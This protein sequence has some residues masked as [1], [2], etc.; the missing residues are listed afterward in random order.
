MEGT[1]SGDMVGLPLAIH[2]I[3]ELRRSDS[4]LM[5]ATFL[6]LIIYLFVYFDVDHIFLKTEIIIV[7][8]QLDGKLQ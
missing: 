7:Y 2:P 5:L 4:F 1:L 6:R 3:V 8:Q